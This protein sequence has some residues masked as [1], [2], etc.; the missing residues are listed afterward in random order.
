MFHSF[1]CSF[2]HLSPRAYIS[3]QWLSCMK[4]GKIKQFSSQNIHLPPPPPRCINLLLLLLYS[5]PL[6][7]LYYKQNL[8]TPHLCIL[9]TLN[10]S[11]NICWEWCPS[12][13]VLNS[14][15]RTAGN[16]VRS[17]TCSWQ[18]RGFQATERWQIDYLFLCPLGIRGIWRLS[19]HTLPCFHMYLFNK[20]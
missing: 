9:Y 1:T 6:V 16:I 7:T 2:C 20:Y 12:M 13:Y 5:S 19:G 3:L 8:P 11:T 14:E 15:L 18:L 10:Y 17:K 4:C